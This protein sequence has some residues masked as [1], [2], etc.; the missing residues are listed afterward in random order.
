VGMNKLYELELK[1]VAFD[2]F[3][4][5]ISVKFEDTGLKNVNFYKELQNIL[6]AEETVLK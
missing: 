2:I 3:R 1:P 4:S 6:K 5:E